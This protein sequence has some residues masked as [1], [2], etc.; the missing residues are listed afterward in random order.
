MWLNAIR[1][2]I[3][4]ALFAAGIVLLIVNPW[5]DGFHAWSLFTGA[6]I[7]VLLLNLLHRMGVDGD[8]DRDREERARRYFDEHGH[9][10]D[11]RPRS[12]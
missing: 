5:D 1:Y 9:W 8:R 3:P 10:P 4:V 7:A 11:Q 6:G 12:S 2:G